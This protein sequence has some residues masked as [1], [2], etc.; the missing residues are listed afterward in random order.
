MTASKVVYP[1]K[2]YYGRRKPLVLAYGKESCLFELKT[3]LSVIFSAV[4][5][6]CRLG[7]ETH[8]GWLSVEVSTY[9]FITYLELADELVVLG[10]DLIIF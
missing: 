1:T 4:Q 7:Y 9:Y 5:I 3:K 2:S 10:Q 8:N 6:C